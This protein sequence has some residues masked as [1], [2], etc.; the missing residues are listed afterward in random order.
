MHKA[1]CPCQTSKVAMAS[2][3]QVE[4]EMPKS[5][6]RSPDINPIENILIPSCEI[7]VE[8][9]GSI[10][11]NITSESYSFQLQFFKY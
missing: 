4:A 8:Y 5:H 2:L 7:S 3:T 6:A 11:E 1:Y 10:T 9:T